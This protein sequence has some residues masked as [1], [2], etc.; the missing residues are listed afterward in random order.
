MKAPSCSE[1]PVATPVLKRWKSL[2]A[3]L[4]GEGRAV[5]NEPAPLPGKDVESH[6]AADEY[7][8]RRLGRYEKARDAGRRVVHM[9]FDAAALERSRSLRKLDEELREVTR[10]AQEASHG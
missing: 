4:I 5:P 3:I 1:L 7:V 10:L 6:R 8:K 9:D 2:T